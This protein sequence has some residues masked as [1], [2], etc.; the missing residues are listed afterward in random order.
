MVERNY[1]HYSLPAVSIITRA[2]HLYDFPVVTYW[3]R[4]VLFLFKYLHI[5]HLSFLRF[6]FWYFIDASFTWHWVC[7]RTIPYVRH[8]LVQ[9]F[10]SSTTTAAVSIDSSRHHL[11]FCL[12]KSQRCGNYYWR[13]SIFIQLLEIIDVWG[14][15]SDSMEFVP[16]FYHQHQNGSVVMFEVRSEVNKMWLCHKC[17]VVL[18]HVSRKKSTQNCPARN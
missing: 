11:T 16:L 14:P 6:Q 8:F 2:C 10:V 4:Q 15:K 7:I 9:F 12:Q 5:L 13:N 18:K 3:S 17:F 1:R